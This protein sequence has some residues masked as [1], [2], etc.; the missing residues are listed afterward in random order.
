MALPDEINIPK[1]VDSF[2]YL[3]KNMDP[4]L[5]ICPFSPTTF[6]MQSEVS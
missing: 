3:M 2:G 1:L 5:K 6:C 4:F